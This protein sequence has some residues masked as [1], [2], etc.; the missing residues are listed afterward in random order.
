MGDTRISIVMPVRDE[1]DNIS[2]CL[3]RLVHALAGT[4]YELLICY[5]TDDD[6]TLPAIESAVVKPDRIVL[7]KNEL[8]AGPSFAMRAGLARA[9]GDVLVTT[10]ADL[11]DPPEIILLM[12]NEVRQRHADVVSGSRYMR[13]GKQVG[14]P[15]L[16]SFLSRA[17]G[18]SL[19]FLSGIGTHDATTNFRAFSRRLIDCVRIESGRAFS[20]GLELTIAAHLLGFRVT[21]V[22]ST[23]TERHAGESR[24]RLGPW[25]PQYLR[26][27]ARAAR[28]PVFVLCVWLVVAAV[29]ATQL[30]FAI[31]AVAAV[32]TL[33]GILLARR[34]RGKTTFVDAALPLLAVLPLPSA[35]AYPGLIRAALAVPI[36]LAAWRRGLA[37]PWIR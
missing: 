16:K 27:Y 15:P 6:S 20:F 7:V 37:R 32:A 2:D 19:Y 9:S 23:W 18:V 36:L 3:A 5:D 1:P 30:S 26:F 4:E 8:G 14:G 25:L 17:A 31:A 12:A 29:V 22:P 24:F 28:A 13:G 33:S 11:S 10:M 34:L 35:V 21:E